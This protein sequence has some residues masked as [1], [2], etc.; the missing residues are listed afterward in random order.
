MR[1]KQEGSFELQ[2]PRSR[3]TRR[4]THRSRRHGRSDRVARQLFDNLEVE[5][6]HLIV[7]ERLQRQ[8]IRRSIMARSF[9]AVPIVDKLTG[10][11]VLNSF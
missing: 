8:A 10:V 7:L 11:G 6:K 4:R 2:A 5:S 3:P 9:V 1:Q